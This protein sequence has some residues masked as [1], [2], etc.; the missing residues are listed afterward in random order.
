MNTSPIITRYLIE[1][2]QHDYLARALRASEA[3]LAREAARARRTRARRMRA[4]ASVRPA[5]RFRSRIRL[6]LLRRAL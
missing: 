4:E 5:H 6:P 1:A 3:R 2:R